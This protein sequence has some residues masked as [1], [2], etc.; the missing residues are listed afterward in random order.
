MD[1]SE[2]KMLSLVVCRISGFA[3]TVISISENAFDQPDFL[4]QPSALHAGL[5]VASRWFKAG[6]LRAPGPET[7]TETETA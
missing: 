7:E 6:Q 5:P 3:G 2:V 4:V 1:Y